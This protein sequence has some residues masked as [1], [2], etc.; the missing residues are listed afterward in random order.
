MPFPYP[1]G[2]REPMPVDPTE[3]KVGA[4]MELEHSR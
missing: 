3:V 1:V 4:K 2:V